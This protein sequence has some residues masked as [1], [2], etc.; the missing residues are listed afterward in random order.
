MHHMTGVW[1]NAPTEGGGGGAQRASV[2]V[3]ATF[4]TM[5][6]NTRV[7]TGCGASAPAHINVTHV[8]W[9]NAILEQRRHRFS[10]WLV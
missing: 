8:G 4:A 1:R 6:L 3:V 7:V 10:A 9:D 2:Q 5:H